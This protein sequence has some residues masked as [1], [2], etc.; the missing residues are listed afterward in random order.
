MSQPPKD[1]AVPAATA[2][3][4]DFET[5]LGHQFE[6]RALLA[7]ALTHRSFGTPNN[8]R[9]EFL[10]DGL[11]N[12][13]VADE[14]YRRFPKLRE[15]ELSRLRAFLVK[16]STLFEVAQRLRLG[17]AL[18]LGDGELRSGGGDRPSILA[19]GFEALVG[20]IYLDAG[21]DR[22]R[23]VVVDLLRPLFGGLDT[24]AA[25]KDPK[26]ELQEYL[27]GRHL[28]LPTYQ[29]VGTSGAAHRQRFEV[30]CLIDG[31]GLQTAGHGS[32]RRVAEQS[33]A[34]EALAAVRSRA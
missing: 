4:P 1:E 31:L 7:E 10:G 32:S 9:L 12:C 19:D 22:T 16:E 20:A 15:G 17:D 30:H 3:A 2:D 25:L 14:L 33:A 29:V 27:Q 13:I 21:F 26:T 8:E 28:P 34:R 6:D 5:R 23:R 11:L 24:R 18:H